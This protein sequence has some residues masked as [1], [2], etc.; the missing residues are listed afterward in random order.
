MK[1]VLSRKF[2]IIFCS[3]K[4]DSLDLTFVTLSAV[5]KVRLLLSFSFLG[6]NIEFSSEIPR[7]LG[8]KNFRLLAYAHFHAVII[9]TDC[10]FTKLTRKKNFRMESINKVVPKAKEYAWKGFVVGSVGALVYLVV[11]NFRLF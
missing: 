8:H 9:T 7:A 3:R 4:M 2:L 1:S 10:K 11:S 6:K 5:S